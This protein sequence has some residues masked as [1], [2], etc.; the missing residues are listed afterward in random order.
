MCFVASK[1]DMAA[2]SRAGNA[3]TGGEGG[4][5]DISLRVAGGV[6]GDG[7]KRTGTDGV[8]RRM[9][10]EHLGIL[11]KLDTHGVVVRKRDTQDKGGRADV[12]GDAV[13]VG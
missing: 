8:G 10:A 13:K 5:V 7:T 12:L 9:I 4:E 11:A 6:H 2:S 1:R 3:L